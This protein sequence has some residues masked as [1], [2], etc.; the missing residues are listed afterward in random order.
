MK[1]SIYFN[2]KNTWKYGTYFSSMRTKKDF[3]PKIESKNIK[4]KKKEK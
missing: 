4:K 3:G 1:I 2:I